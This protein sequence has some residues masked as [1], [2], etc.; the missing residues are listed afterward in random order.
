MECRTTLLQQSAGV[1]GVLR[2]S[3]K[4]EFKH[5]T[6]VL[7]RG[8]LDVQVFRDHR[9]KYRCVLKRGTGQPGRT[10]PLFTG[11]IR[12]AQVKVGL[13]LERRNSQR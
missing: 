4:G 10:V 7:R 8:F 12:R 6:A 1:G 3:L 9:C 2:H 13:R 11:T 5:V